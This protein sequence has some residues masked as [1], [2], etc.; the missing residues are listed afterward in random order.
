MT[1]FWQLFQQ[2]LLFLVILYMLLSILIVSLKLNTTATTGSEIFWNSPQNCK[3]Y[4]NWWT[5]SL[6]CSALPVRSAQ[7]LLIYH[8]QKSVMG[9]AGSSYSAYAMPWLLARH[10][11]APTR[12]Y[13]AI[14]QRSQCWWATTCLCRDEESNPSLPST[15]KS[16][17][18]LGHCSSQSLSSVTLTSAPSAL[19]SLICI[20]PPIFLHSIL[21]LM[22]LQID[23]ILNRYFEYYWMKSCTSFRFNR[24]IILCLD[25]LNKFAKSLNKIQE[26]SS[27]KKSP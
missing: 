4:H 8:P 9:W 15:E 18:P 27:A 7:L 6:F 17:L 21:A 22:R 2:T 14:I 26:N 10:S 11:T 25:L 19:S 16:A 1:V 12:E 20:V 23:L 24:N 13:Y 5:V 3:L